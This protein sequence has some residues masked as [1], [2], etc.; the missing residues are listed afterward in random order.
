MFF[1]YRVEKAR[2][3]ILSDQVLESD[4]G[5]EDDSGEE[6]SDDGDSS[7]TSCLGEMVMRLWLKR[8]ALLDSDYAKAGWMLCVQPDI[9]AD[10][11]LRG[12][13][14]DE[15]LAMERV[16]EKL[17]LPPC[18]NKSRNLTGKTSTQIIDLFWDEYK[19]FKDKSPPFNRPGS[20]LTDGVFNGRSYIW[21][22]KYS[23][24]YTEVLGF[25]A[26][27]VCS[28]VLGIG[29]AE[30]AWGDLKLVKS[31]NR[32]IM[33]GDSTE[34]SSIIYTSAR[35]VSHRAQQVENDRVGYKANN[36]FGDDDMK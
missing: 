24:P 7:A 25:V 12:A 5:T 21:H 26:C 17:H 30:R 4:E 31:G 36:M 13:G 1:H 35:L 23:E 15:R 19:A 27:R 14:S 18:P 8:K 28:K 11:A 9:L 34:K 10:V 29:M 20:F 16:I 32:A 3:E 2:Q 6:D 33:V 22:Q